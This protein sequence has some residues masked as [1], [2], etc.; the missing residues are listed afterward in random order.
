MELGSEERATG[1]AAKDSLRPLLEEAGL[2]RSD[3]YDSY[4]ARID[5]ALKATKERMTTTERDKFLQS[6]DEEI[7]NRDEF[8]EMRPPVSLEDFQHSWQ[9]ELEW[10]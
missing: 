7:L 1:P 8:K 9:E 5:S 2:R 4:T 10:V 3:M 6:L